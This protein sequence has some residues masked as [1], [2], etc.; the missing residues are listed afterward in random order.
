MEHSS[1]VFGGDALNQ[2]SNPNAV[3]FR[4]TKK[5]KRPAAVTPPGV[6]AVAGERNS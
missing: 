1:F 3:K 4:M 2:S 5:E 6:Q